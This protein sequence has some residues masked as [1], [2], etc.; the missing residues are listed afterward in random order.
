MENRTRALQEA[1]MPNKRGTIG[2]R[3]HPEETDWPGLAH[4]EYASACDSLA[5]RSKASFADLR[6]FRPIVRLRK[7]RSRRFTSVLPNWLKDGASLYRANRVAR[8]ERA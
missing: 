4:V 6:R 5:R 3:S 1:V 2:S 7:R 8:D